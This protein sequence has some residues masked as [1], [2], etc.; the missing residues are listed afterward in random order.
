M[1]L[2]WDIAAHLPAMRAEAES[3]MTETVT[4]GTFRMSTDPVT[5]DPVRVAVSVR[6]EGKAR[7]RWASRGVVNANGPDM[8]V[9]AQEPYMS[10]PVGSPRIEVG[11]EV[12]VTA[13]TV[14]PMVVSRLLRVDGEAIS[15]QVTASRY[16]LRE[17]A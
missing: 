15:G 9:S 17:V 1:S 4:V 8:P 2:G 5:L 7:I 10:V 12:L 13:S 6:Y 16:P 14:D 11:D 3:R